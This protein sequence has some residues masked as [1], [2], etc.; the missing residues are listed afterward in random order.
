MSK[1]CRKFDDNT[2]RYY[3]AVKKISHFLQKYLYLICVC[4]AVVVYY[5]F[6]TDIN[7]WDLGYRDGDGYMRAI[8]IRDIINNPSFFEQKIMGSNYP[9]GEILHW[10]RPVD[11]FWLIN[12]IPFLGMDNIKDAIFMAGAFMGG[13]LCVA[14]VIALCYGLRRH[15]NVFL[16][17]IGVFLFLMHQT[18]SVYFGFDVADHHSLCLFLEIY[19]FSLILC[20]LKK[21]QN[22]YLMRLGFALSLLTFT[23]I[24]GILVYISFLLFF[25][26]LYIYKNFAIKAARVVSWYFVLFLTFF[27]LLNPPY[28]GWFY[29]DNGRISILFVVL[30]WLIFIG[31]TV[32]DKYKVHTRLYKFISLSCMGGMVLCLLIFI[33]GKDVINPPIDNELMEIWSIRIKE[34]YSVFRYNWK[35]IYC[36]YT[37]Y[38]VSMIL[39]IFSFRFKRYNRIL[40]F[41]LVIGV[42]FGVLSMY[43][44][45]FYMYMAITSII[46]FLVLI[47]YVY[48]NTS[49]Y[50][51]K[52]GDFPIGIWWLIIC[53]FSIEIV[54]FINFERSSNKD[55]SGINSNY[56]Y[57]I[58][59]SEGGTLVTDVFLSANFMFMSDVNVVGTAYHRNREGII[60]NHNI[61]YA[62]NDYELIVLLLKHQ[63][64]QILLF[65]YENDKYYSMDEANKDRLYYRLIKK[66]N[67]PDFL[68]IIPVNNSKII[69][70]RV[71]I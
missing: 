49:F 58:V 71:K 5:A 12:L 22:R 17:L 15:F 42:F 56:L 44:M 34:M 53:I 40:L 57:S 45:R 69:H 18:N 70:Y 30:G 23:A 64:S 38:L 60:D 36:V 20:W 61:L 48:K 46:P 52:K 33:F 3:R 66:E 2:L 19:A 25:I 16:V 63:V 24:E 4:F 32:I 31:F 13:W 10:T 29:P 39:N 7:V 1:N 59:K 67:V 54:S 65:N 51:N 21:R 55:N 27:W 6:A 26:Y 43:A 9:F 35:Q 37:F 50:R 68:E 62:T 8:R 14:S 11:V 28:Q 41:N 47:D